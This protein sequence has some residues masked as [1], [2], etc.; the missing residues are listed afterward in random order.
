MNNLTMYRRFGWLPVLA[1]GLVTF[2]GAVTP[3]PTASRRTACTTAKYRQFDFFTGDWDTYDFTD[4]TKIIARN[5]VSRMLDGCAIREVYDQYD[6]MHGESFSMYDAARDVWHQ[7]WVTNGGKLLL[8]DGGVQ[9]TSMIF[10]GTVKEANGKSS[11]LRGTWTPQHGSVRETAVTSADGGKTWKPV[12]DIIF[13]PHN[14]HNG[15]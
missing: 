3:S 11:L 14:Q 8:M 10:T 9:G 12:F 4:S 5:H 6:G 7:S 15:S 1:V 2:V 13:R